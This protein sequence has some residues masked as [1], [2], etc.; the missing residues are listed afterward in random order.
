[1]TRRQ[2]R[3]MVRHESVITALIGAAL[4]LLLGIGLAALVTRRLSGFSTSEGGQGMS[5]SIPVP[6]LA[7][8]TLIAI[9]AG[10][11]AAIVPARRAAR[12]NVL[13]ALAYE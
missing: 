12:L 7:V 13:E 6:T 1:M 11:L 2:M 8:F 9:I 4:G 5:L 3:R 10:V